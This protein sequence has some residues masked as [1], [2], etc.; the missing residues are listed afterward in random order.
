MNKNI[1]ITTIIALLTTF[2]YISNTSSYVPFT[3]T[4]TPQKPVD[5]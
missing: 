4:P 3:P 2:G 1:L 5:I